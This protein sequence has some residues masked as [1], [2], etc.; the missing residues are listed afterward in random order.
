N[1]YQSAVLTIGKAFL[2]NDQYV[3][4]ADF[5]KDNRVDEKD[6]SLFNGQYKSTADGTRIK[7]DGITY[8]MTKEDRFYRFDDAS[9]SSVYSFGDGKLVTLNQIPYLI[10]ERNGQTV[11][12]EHKLSDVNHDGSVNDDDQKAISD[13]ILLGQYN[14]NMDLDQNG[15]VNYEDLRIFDVT[16]AREGETQRIR[17]TE[18]VY[19]VTRQRSGF[20][21]FDDKVH[22]PVFSDA[23]R[24][25]RINGRSYAI[26]IDETNGG[27]ELV[28]L[29]SFDLNQDGLIDQKDDQLLADNVRALRYKT[30]L[31]GFRN[32]STHAETIPSDQP[33]IATVSDWKDMNGSIQENTDPNAQEMPGM[34]GDMNFRPKKWAEYNVYVEEEGDYEVGFSAKNTSDFS[35][36]NAW[37]GWRFDRNGQGGYVYGS[38]TGA[39][40]TSAGTLQTTVR[41]N[42]PYLYIPSDGMWVFDRDSMAWKQQTAQI[43]ADLNKVIKV[44]MKIA[45]SP[46]TK[47]KIYW[48]HAG[49]AADTFSEAKSEWFPLS[50]PAIVNGEFY[51]YS[52]DLSNHANWNGTINQLRLDPIDD[53]NVSVGT[54]EL[55]SISVCPSDSAQ[56]VQV[57]GKNPQAAQGQFTFAFY[58]DSNMDQWSKGSLKGHV[59]TAWDNQNY[60]YG[61]AKIHLTKGNHRIMYEWLNETEE[62]DIAIQDMFL[63]RADKRADLNADCQVDEKDTALYES[64]KAVYLSNSSVR[65]GG[66]N[67]NLLKKAE[68]SDYEVSWIKDGS[69]SS[70]SDFY[71]HAVKIQD[72]DFV[73][74]NDRTADRVLLVQPGF[75]S[76]TT[77]H[78]V[79]KIDNIRYNA[80]KRSDGSYYLTTVVKEAEETNGKLRV[81]NLDYE[82]T[83]LEEDQSV[84]LKSVEDLPVKAVSTKTGRSEFTV[85]GVKVDDRLWKR[86]VNVVVID[87]T[88]KAQVMRNFDTL[89]DVRQNQELMRFINNIE[90]GSYILVA[91]EGERAC[92]DYEY[93]GEC[94]RSVA[95]SL[96]QDARNAIQSVGSDQ[97]QF[98]KDTQRLAIIGRKGAARG[99]AAEQLAEG[100]YD[101]PDATIESSVTIRENKMWHTQP[102]GRVFIDQKLYLLQDQDGKKVLMKEASFDS[103]VDPADSKT[104]VQLFDGNV[105]TI[106]Q[107]EDG[108]VTLSLGTQ[109]SEKIADG[110]LEIDSQVFDVNFDG[111][112]YVFTRGTDRI[113]SVQENGITYL[114][115]GEATYE[116]VKDP[117][118]IHLKKTT[119]GIQEIKG[120]Q[121]LIAINNVVYSVIPN[122]DDLTGTTYR[123]LD[124]KHFFN[125]SIE[126]GKQQ[127]IIDGVLF[128]QTVDSKG[129]VFVRRPVI[130]SQKI[131]DQEF[132]IDGR[133]FYRLDKEG[134]T[135]QFIDIKSGDRYDSAVKNEGRN[136][137]P[138][139]EIKMKDGTYSTFTITVDSVTGNL[140]LAEVIRSTETDEN[141]K[142]TLGAGE[143]TVKKFVGGTYS[144]TDK[145]GIE[146]MNS[147]NDVEGKMMIELNGYFYDIHD[148]TVIKLHQPKMVDK[149]LTVGDFNNDRVIDMQDI[150]EFIRIG[151]HYKDVNGDGKV[152]D[153]DTWSL[154]KIIYLQDVVKEVTPQNIDELKKLA[155]VNKDL[156]INYKDANALADVITGRYDINRDSETDEDDYKLMIAVLDDLRDGKALQ[157]GIINAVDFNKDKKVDDA[158]RKLLFDLLTKDLNFDKQSPELNK[159]DIARLHDIIRGVSLGV[160]ETEIRLANVRPDAVIDSQDADYIRYAISKYPLM[161]VKLDLNGDD[162]LDVKDLQIMQRSA[163]AVKDSSVLDMQKLLKAD[164]NED[165]VINL[166]DVF[167]LRNALIGRVDVNGD[168]QINSGDVTK[169]SNVLEYL[170]LNVRQS[171][172]LRLTSY[173]AVRSL[174]VADEVI[175]INDRIFKV[176]KDTTGRYVLS[177][178]GQNYVAFFGLNFVEI[179]GIIYDIFEREDGK[180]QLIQQHAKSLRV[181]GERIQTFGKIYRVTSLG[182]GRFEFKDTESGE[183]QSEKIGNTVYLNGTYYAVTDDQANQSAVLVQVHAESSHVSDERVAL[184]NTEYDISYDRLKNTYEVTGPAGF[185]AVI[186]RDGQSVEIEGVT[187][188][189]Y[190]DE[191]RNRISFVSTEK[192]SKFIAEGVILLEGTRFVVNDNRDGT[193]TFT[194]LDDGLVAISNPETGKVSIHNVLYDILENP[195]TNAVS[196]EQTHR[197]SL[198]VADQVI[199][200]A[201]TDYEVD[202]NLDGTFT[203][204]WDDGK[205]AS[206]TLLK[207][208]EVA[209]ESVT[210]DIKMDYAAGRIKLVQRYRV[211][212]T[213]FN[214]QTGQRELKFDPR[215]KASIAVKMNADGTFTVNGKTTTKENPNLVQIGTSWFN[216]YYNPDNGNIKLEEAHKV[217]QTLFGQLIEFNGEAYEVI[218]NQN[219]TFTFAGIYKTFTS[220]AELGKVNLDSVICDVQV[221]TYSGNIKLIEEHSS[222]SKPLY[223]G[224]ALIAGKQY[225]LL[226]AKGGAYLL[227]DESASTDALT[228]RSKP[229]GTP[230]DLDG[231]GL[232][233]DEEAKQGTSEL[234]PDS[235]SDG[236]SDTYEIKAGTNPL[237]LASKPSAVVLDTDGDGMSDYEELE[238]GFNPIRPD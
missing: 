100:T 176:T 112:K 19:D 92:G 5:N 85:D 33:T 43:N 183:T 32:S 194:G 178:G 25:V 11:L 103:A 7:I 81:H 67:Y 59:N 216:I 16:R 167:M 107:I 86:G 64:R 162:R 78:T 204:T 2:T 23:D 1:P 148:N 89:G 214:A 157:P 173:D 197:R 93:S 201:E 104:K 57:F 174:H 177:D 72:L 15:V 155:D 52:I 34:M 171:K 94:G 175:R 84:L 213:S 150:T 154:E 135:Y 30:D 63:S 191:Q 196:L 38:M 96:S 65:L 17:L 51:E 229:Q 168:G 133:P 179:D 187:F 205:G 115:L 166:Q 218:R 10:F 122:P 219:G 106:T 53:E 224:I 99:T 182:E 123:F 3:R 163:N 120:R 186:R 28:E 226:D 137:I 125:T 233:N 42:N 41:G 193:Y 12:V 139:V 210:Y 231:D 222:V 215:D 31:A 111:E 108:T 24:H 211:A 36:V 158:D 46:A 217:S 26:V 47:A 114:P 130:I 119:F 126:N 141:Y 95:N 13:T 91:L 159:E 27:I 156:V 82:M 20:Y 44:K 232:T 234:S 235:D 14:S 207:P 127:L 138:I 238:A 70:T 74:I 136:V 40:Y 45:N 18:T 208:Y 102:D 73:M 203:F 206:S 54:V 77:A 169:I 60:Q 83:T 4:S 75:D 192:E 116:I 160:T 90:V 98:V 152:D 61:S 56:A 50:E 181:D 22:A 118:G 199:R 87:P 227:V 228:D 101:E 165:G 170:G 131:A 21:M 117:E 39:V 149:V 71:T 132:T 134:G 202:Y 153:R 185:A 37:R 230:E 62:T 225:Y 221:D 164:L 220:N 161:R 110:A 128:E 236:F 212:E 79:L 105:Y 209:L 68:S 8:Y 145:Y 129:H 35:A 144:L 97:I 88:T 200:I 237:S 49:D 188:T 146:R 190:I 180:I 147:W 6:I 113:D 58:A 55:E 66:K 9:Q 198:K 223:D 80:V 124:G 172:D 189:A 151:G 184:K 195:F 76:K 140:T 143:Y 48:N 69:V 109:V 142:V 121:Y 29:M